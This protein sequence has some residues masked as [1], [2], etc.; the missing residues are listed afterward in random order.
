MAKEKT[1]FANLAHVVIALVALVAIVGVTAMFLNLKNIPNGNAWAWGSVNAQEQTPGSINSLREFGERCSSDSQCASGN[2]DG[3][4][5]VK[6]GGKIL[7]NVF[8]CV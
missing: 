2:C 8:V 4:I 1:D 3:P 6:Q 5:Y 7:E